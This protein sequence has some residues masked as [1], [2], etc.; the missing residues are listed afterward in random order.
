MKSIVKFLHYKRENQ[1]KLSN[2]AKQKND[3]TIQ[4]HLHVLD[5]NNENLVSKRK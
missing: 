4:K 5:C 1:N 3:Y 2:V